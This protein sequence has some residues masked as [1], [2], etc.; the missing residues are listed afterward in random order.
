MESNRFYNHIEA[1][2]N[3]GL[4]E[5]SLAAFEHALA[6]DEDLQREVMLFK[7]E[8]KAM[9]HLEKFLAEH[10]DIRTKS[11][12]RSLFST[13]LTVGTFWTRAKAA[14]SKEGKKQSDSNDRGIPG[15]N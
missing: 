15:S 4:D 9:D 2:L 13:A 8:Q 1:Y 3:G 7:T 5:E 11:W 6:Q 12:L 10:D 14:E